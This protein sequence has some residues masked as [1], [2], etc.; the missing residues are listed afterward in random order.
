MLACVLGEGF[1]FFHAK[2]IKKYLLLSTFSFGSSAVGSKLV[3]QPAVA[4]WAGFGL[5]SHKTSFAVFLSS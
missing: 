4:S 1:H 5:I 3:F 2:S